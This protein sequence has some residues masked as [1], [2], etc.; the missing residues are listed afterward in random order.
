M[1]ELVS[2]DSLRARGKQLSIYTR[3]GSLLRT[4]V[5]IRF[6]SEVT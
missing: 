6:V 4:A 1:S 5:R 2:R 3:S